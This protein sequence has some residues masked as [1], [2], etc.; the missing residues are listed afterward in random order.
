LRTVANKT[1]D[2]FRFHV[3]GGGRSSD[4][5]TNGFGWV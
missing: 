1:N 5:K 3:G 2:G 4:R